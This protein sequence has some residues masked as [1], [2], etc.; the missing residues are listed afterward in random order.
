MKKI[1]RIIII[2]WSIIFLLGL[3]WSMMAGLEN[4]SRHGSNSDAAAI[5]TM[6]GMLVLL[7]FWSII[8]GVVA[9]PALVINLL[10]KD[11]KTQSPS[12]SS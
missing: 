12:H 8:W 5:G 1:T 9:V 7:I 11:G 6:A 10:S 4:V 2:G 3:C